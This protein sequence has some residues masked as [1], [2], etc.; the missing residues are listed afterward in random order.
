M[1]LRTAMLSTLAVLMFAGCFQPDTDV[2]T[3][4]PGTEPPGQL[5]GA[6]GGVNS[7][8]G[9]TTP[10]SVTSLHLTVRTSSFNGR[11]KPDNV[12]AIWIETAA[13][14]FV[15][16]VE[17]WGKNRARYITRWNAA[18]G[19]NVVDA[20][21]SA[22][23]ATHI[24]HDRTWDFTDKQSCKVAPGNYKLEVEHTDYNGTGALLEVPFTAIPGM[25]TLPD[26][27]YFHGVVLEIQ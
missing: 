18:S 11:Y 10:A 4:E 26:S 12:G 9:D 17:R 20:V 3:I 6:D 1:S 7:T 8:C 13:G 24:T 22:T 15:R 21:T 2:D 19:G 25:Q 27:T 5:F 14:A 16:T 23:L